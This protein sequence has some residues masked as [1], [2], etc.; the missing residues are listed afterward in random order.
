MMRRTPNSKVE[1]FRIASGTHGSDASYGNNGH[2]IFRFNGVVLIVI[3][4]DGE[5]W[6]H[7]SVS[8]KSR[9]PNGKKCVSSKTCSLM[10]KRR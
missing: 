3:V 1:S 4:S 8:T 2:F 10:T 9:V 5:S 6:D 7:I